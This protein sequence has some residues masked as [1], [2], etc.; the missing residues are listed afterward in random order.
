MTC[1]LNSYT[2]RFL[3]KN[4]T[5][6]VWRQQYSSFSPLS[7]QVAGHVKILIVD[8]FA[9]CVSPLDGC[10]LRNDSPSSSIVGAAVHRMAILHQFSFSLSSTAVDNPRMT[11]HLYRVSSLSLLTSMCQ[12]IFC[13]KSNAPL[14]NFPKF[15]LVHSPPKFN[16]I[17]Q[18]L[19]NMSWTNH[20]K[21][22][23][24]RICLWNWSKW[25]YCV[26]QS[27]QGPGLTRTGVL[28][29]ISTD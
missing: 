11:R 1:P 29:E 2:H 9:A 16:R 6:L 7:S 27:C 18:S 22:S 14:R 23:K 25:D 24:S 8:S 15:E 21:T 17:L 20:L 5:I 4:E 10:S 19:E 3:E 13:Y 28:Y 26:S 12:S